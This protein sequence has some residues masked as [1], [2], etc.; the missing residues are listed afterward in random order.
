ML[1]AQALPLANAVASD[2]VVLHQVI[3]QNRLS[4]ILALFSLR[5]SRC[6]YRCAAALAKAVGHIP[7]VTGCRAALTIGCAYLDHTPLAQAKICVDLPGRVLFLAC[8]AGDPKFRSFCCLRLRSAG[9]KEQ[10]K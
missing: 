8:K 5:F 1:A 6:F 2:A 4:A 3:C 9:S 7:D 10:E